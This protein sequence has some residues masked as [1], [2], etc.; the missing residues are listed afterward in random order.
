MAPAAENGAGIVLCLFKELVNDG[1]K[2][3]ADAIGQ[4]AVVADIA[5]IMVWDMSDETR[6]EFAG[7]EGNG[8]NG[9]GIMIKVF[10]DN[11]FMVV[12]FDA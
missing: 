11:V 4:K 5:E 2:F 7:G 1:K 9:I 6:Q 12:R 10:E 8:L 3:A